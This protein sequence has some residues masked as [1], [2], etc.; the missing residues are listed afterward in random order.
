MDTTSSE[1]DRQIDALFAAIKQE[2][3]SPAAPVPIDETACLWD[4][5]GLLGLSGVVYILFLL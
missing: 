4:S 3:D 2:L 5:L 1:T